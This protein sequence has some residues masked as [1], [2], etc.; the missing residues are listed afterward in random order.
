MSIL[1]VKNLRKSYPQKKHFFAVDDISFE[2]KEGEILGLLGPNGSGKTTT[3]QMLLGT[4]LATSGSIIYFGKNFY[5]HKSDILKHVTFACAYTNLPWLLTVKEV[6]L[7]FGRFYCISPK[8][9]LKLTAPLLDRF[10]MLK[11]INDK[12]SSL[13]AGQ[14]TR[15]ILI[16][17]F[18]MSP[19]VILLDEPTASLD[20]DMAKE[21][22]DFILQQRKEKK[23]SVLFTSHKMEE[24]AKLCDRVIFL[25]DGKIIAN[26]LP[27]NLAKTISSF[28]VT[29]NILDGM[30]RICELCTQSNLSYKVDYRT[31]EIQLDEKILPSL[32]NS[33][34]RL[35]ILYSDIEIQKPSLEDYFLKIARR[36]K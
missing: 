19:K 9:T 10:G 32:L 5:Q 33:I 18:F 29:L 14:I 16:K 6:L 2:L 28:T 27:K 12:I 8:E 17:A 34:G 35:N 13:S 36:K 24:A 30:K 15:L 4:L 31:I 23:I 26:D 21:I 3:I 20:P 22:C 7:I 25:K 11:K 1:E